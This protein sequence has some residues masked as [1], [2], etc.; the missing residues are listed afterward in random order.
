MNN[1]DKEGQEIEAENDFE[2]SED[3]SASFTELAEEYG[4]EHDCPIFIGLSDYVKFV[5]GSTIAAARAVIDGRVD[6]AIHWDGGRHHAKKSECQGFCYV[7]D[8]VLGIIELRRV[9]SAFLYTDKVMTISFHHHARGFYPGSGALT[10]IGQGK[11]MYHTINV[12]LRKGLRGARFLQIAEHVLGHAYN[13]FQPD[14]IVV[15]CGCDGLAGDPAREWNLDIQSFGQCVQGIASW[16]KPAIFLG[17]GG[18]NHANVAR[19]NAYMTSFLIDGGISIQEDIPEH[20]Y[21]EEYGPDFSLLVDTGNRPDL[22]DDE[23]LASVVN[24]ILGYFKNIEER[25]NCH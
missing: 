18:Y 1:I 8:I 5:A 9:E 13:T 20:Q 23:Y 15:Q 3:S 4:L 22:N 24:V 19:C 6:I 12:P 25:N 2:D 11:G 7:N 14:A 16:N 21:F 10:D 17:G